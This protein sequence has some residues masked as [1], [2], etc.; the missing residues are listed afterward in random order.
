MELAEQ[1]IFEIGIFTLLKTYKTATATIRF[2]AD[3]PL[4]VLLVENIVK[5]RIEEK[6]EVM[7]RR[8]CPER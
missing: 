2:S 3:K 8:K 6:Q 1:L 7:V 4:P 5:A